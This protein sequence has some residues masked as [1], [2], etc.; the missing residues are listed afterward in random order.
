M[1]STERWTDEAENIVAMELEDVLPREVGALPDEAFYVDARRILTALADAGLLLPPGGEVREEWTAEVDL[2]SGWK[3]RP[4]ITTS[5][6]EPESVYKADI[7]DYL[8]G[9]VKP[10]RKLCRTVH[11]GPWR[12][13]ESEGAPDGR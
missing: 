4:Y 6:H 9:I 1:A 12:P 10:K 13:A 3:R 11:I 2:G 5:D 7:D 8:R